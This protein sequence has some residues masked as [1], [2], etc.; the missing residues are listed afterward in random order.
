[1]CQLVGGCLIDVFFEYEGH[2]GIYRVTQ[3]RRSTFSANC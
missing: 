2:L 1:L 3:R